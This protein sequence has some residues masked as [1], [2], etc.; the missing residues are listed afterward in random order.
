MAAGM[1]RVV[2]A[3]ARS[4]LRGVRRRSDLSS[5]AAP[6]TPPRS[7]SRRPRAGSTRE[8][9]DG[10]PRGKWWEIYNDPQLNALEEQVEHLEPERDRRDGAVPR[11]ARPGAHRARGALSDGDR[12]AGDRRDRRRARSR[13]G[14]G[15]G[16]PSS[17]VA[18][19]GIGRRLHAAGRRVVSGRRLGQHP[20][21]R[22]GERRDRAGVG[23]RSREREADVSGAARRRSTSSCTVST[24]TPTCCSGR[25][26][27]YRAVAAAD[28]G[29]LRRRRRVGRRRGAGE[30]AARHRRA[31]S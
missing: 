22:R 21:Q 1:L 6:V 15:V 2:A 19:S 8:P 29:S 14:S 11:G 10:I 13:R 7:R 18:A 4:R 31:R 26:T 17:A 30:D 3:V 23:R 5:A 25:V 27:L 9:N 16:T 28:A 12:D 24:A 20:A